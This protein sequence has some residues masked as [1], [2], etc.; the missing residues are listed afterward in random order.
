M[1]KR[2]LVSLAIAMLGVSG[3][4]GS[5]LAQAQEASTGVVYT[6]DIPAQSLGDALQALALISSREFLYSSRLVEGVRSVPLKGLFTAEE[7]IRVLLQG[8]NL[9]YEITTDGLVVIRKVAAGVVSGSLDGRGLPVALADSE[10]NG[11][12]LAQSKSGEARSPSSAGVIEATDT[13]K[14]LLLKGIPEILV[15]GTRSMN[16]DIERTSDDMQPYVVFD[17]AQIE[18]SGAVSLDQ[19]FQ[20]RLTMSSGAVNRRDGTST[21]VSLRGLGPGQTLILIDGRRM[22]G[23]SVYGTPGQ[24]ETGY[25]TSGQAD[26]SG[27]PLAAIERIEVLPATASG[28]YGG[29]ATGGAINIILRR[30]YS[31]AE[32]NLTYENTFASNT[33]SGK[34]DL[35]FGH[36][37]N[38]GR[39]SLLVGTHFSDAATLYASDRRLVQQGR[40]QI[41]RNNPGYFVS[42]TG[43]PPLGNRPNISSSNG[44][45][46][47]LDDGTPLGAS[48]TSVPQGYQGVGSDGGAALASRAGVY[49]WDLADAPSADSRGSG[50]RQSLNG[51]EQAKFGMASL[52]HEFSESLQGFLD[53]SASD[54]ERVFFTEGNG[55]NFTIPADAANNPFMQPISVTLPLSGL[56]DQQTT[57]I[58]G[59]RGALGLI[60]RLSHGWLTSADFSWSRAS[61]V[62]HGAARRGSGFN[63]AVSSG[64]LDVL[65]DTQML[66][67]DVT[68]YLVAA[69]RWT[70]FKSTMK[71][72]AVRIAGPAWTLPAGPMMFSAALS[73]RNEDLDESWLHYP[74]SNISQFYPER[75]QEVKSAY[76]E[77]LIPFFSAENARTG[78]R[79]LDLQIAVR[80]DNYTSASG[81]TVELAYTADQSPP[82]GF[83][84]GRSEFTSVDPTI[85]LRWMP[86]QD[87]T[88]RI[89]YGTGFLPPSLSQ[90]VTSTIVGQV[91]PW[92]TDPL[93]GNTQAGDG[94]AG[95]FTQLNGGNPN[96]KPEQ[97]VSWSAGL[98]LTPRVLPGMRLS[99]DYTRI[100]KTDAISEHPRTIQGLIDDESLFPGRIVRGPNLPDD[101]E[102]WAGPIILI[103]NTYMNLAE[104]WLE[105]WDVR[106]DSRHDMDRYGTVELMLLG[107]W[108][109][110]YMTRA[111]PWLEEAENVAMGSW[112]PLKFKATAS[113]LW[114]KDAWRVGWNTS[115]YDSYRLA[116]WSAAESIDSQGNQGW[117]PKQIYHDLFVSY[118][119]GIRDSLRFLDKTQLQFGVRNVFDKA[120]PLD[121]NARLIGMFSPLGDARMAMY[122][123]S[124]KKGF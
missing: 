84:R 74:S 42:P 25:G 77:L 76:M 58:K 106:L 52:R 1:H 90:L 33:P 71:D 35:S 45:P 69:D 87:L 65:R 97:S 101:P 114:S 36:H 111:L 119:F 115:Y 117:V 46:L 86:V 61:I 95:P 100:K 60:K 54:R 22:T 3:V 30:D 93:R 123:L 98:I 64:T 78:L 13:S 102:G 28:I 67:I 85:A 94:P 20:Q 10:T 43:R 73:Y 70:P 72:T 107:T 104:S 56:D 17:R 49:N 4:A 79:E 2:G 66:P 11:I 109:P 29:S 108:Q 32:A 7:A 15:T 81:E 124:I 40:A 41:L 88:A 48:F 118:D 12:R 99:V 21:S 8:T 92:Y 26:V 31:G 14:D 24:T 55:V 9:N 50:G 16:M 83:A 91:G 63:S 103:D 19:F 82:V 105:A 18:R 51:P 27:I 47:V 75:S 37:F 39:T 96:L 80:A 23:P 113:L 68:S 34:V 62:S 53:L 44:T 120:P 5:A 59:A 110:H 6:L 122:S 57:T 116:S 89:S 121:V 38:E 112:N